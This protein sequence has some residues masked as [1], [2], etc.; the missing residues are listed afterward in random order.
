MMKKIT[1]LD[2]KRMKAEGKRIVMITAYDYAFAKIFDPLVDVILV[3]DSLGTVVYGY[4]TT[5]PVTMDDMVRHTSAVARGRKRAFLVADMPFMSFQV[6][7]EKAVEN[8][9]L[10]L[11]EGGAEAVK[12]EGGVTMFETIRKITSCDIPVM[13]HV[14]LTPQSIHRMG[15]YRIQGREKE[16]RKRLLE[17]A[18]AVEEAGAFS[19]V[20]EGI[21][22]EVAEE[23]TESV[24]IPTIGIG[25][26]PY[27]DGQV[28]VMHDLLGL[29]LDFKPKFVKRYAELAPVV[30][31]AVKEFAREVREGKFPD[32][33]HTFFLEEK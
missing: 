27:C 16:A 33:E 24:S 21:P 8:A 18:K 22:S 13:G 3:G 29:F 6:S 7:P 12:L 20:L 28:L 4:E 25:A 19:L 11:K 17:D 32:S 10:L 30:E 2:L 9:C 1:V 14:G 31:E 15:G 26:G 5:L 23:I